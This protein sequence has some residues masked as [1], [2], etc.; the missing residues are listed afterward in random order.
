MIHSFPFEKDLKSK[1]L[2]VFDLDE[3]LVHCV[4]KNIS[5]ADVQLT[6]KTSNGKNS[7]KYKIGINVR[8]YTIE[9]LKAIKKYYVVIIYTASHRAYADKVLDYLDPKNEIFEYRLYRDNC[10]KVKMEE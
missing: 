6:I 1:K 5:K 7:E 8:P 10:V 9:S 2:A 4:T 3:T